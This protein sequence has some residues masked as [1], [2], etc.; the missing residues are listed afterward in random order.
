MG[1]LNEWWPEDV[2]YKKA[3]MENKAFGY[4]LMSKAD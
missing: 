1:G 4:E 3:G 2:P